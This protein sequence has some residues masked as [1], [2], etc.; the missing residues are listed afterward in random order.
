M[1]TN[2]YRIWSRILLSVFCITILSGA[3]WAQG[4]AFSFQGRLNDGTTP[5]NG[6]YD[7]QFRLYNAATGG[8]QIGTTTALRP[9][10]TL[11]NGVFSVT[12]DFGATAFNNPNLVFI[13]IGIRPNGSPNAYTI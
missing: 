13:E 7:L 5:A 11:I 6:S 2:N 4:N 12:L 8:T 10:T 1:L 9:N 3:V